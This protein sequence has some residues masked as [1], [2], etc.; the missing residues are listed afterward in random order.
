[1]CWLP[2]RPLCLSPQQTPLL[3]FCTSLK[4]PPDWGG[5]GGRQAVPSS[6][7][8]WC[9]NSGL[10]VD[11]HWTVRTSFCF[12]NCSVMLPKHDCFTALWRG[13]TSAIARAHTKNK[14][15]HCRIKSYRIPQEIMEH[16]LT[17]KYYLCPETNASTNST[18]SGILYPPPWTPP[19][20]QIIT[21]AY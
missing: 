7:W 15:E 2:N 9:N 5:F 1:M 4:D 3:F 19:R 10:A 17:W 11:L 18:E 6:T 13:A 8:R 14:A 20:A 12:I 16:A 21:N